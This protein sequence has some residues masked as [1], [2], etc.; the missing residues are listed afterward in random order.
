MIPAF[1]RTELFSYRISYAIL[2]GRYCYVGMN[3][4]SPSEN[5]TDNKMYS[6]YGE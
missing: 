1:V 6:F 4:L 2:R 5:K 3:A